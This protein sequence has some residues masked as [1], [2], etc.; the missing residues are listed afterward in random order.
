MGGCLECPRCSKKSFGVKRKMVRCVCECVYVHVGNIG[1]LGDV[2][3]QSECDGKPWQNFMQR[4]DMSDFYFKSPSAA[5]WDYTVCV[6]VG[7]WVKGGSRGI[8]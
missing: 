3:F 5:V 6:C 8:I 1:D 4:N 7:G 2:C